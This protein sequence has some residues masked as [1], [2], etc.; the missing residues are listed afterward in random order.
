MTARLNEYYID[1]I[2]TG[3]PATA[4]LKGH[5]Y[6]FEVS[7]TTPQVQDHSFV[8]E[9]K[10]C[11]AQPSLNSQLRSGQS[12]RLQIELSKPEQKII[13]PRGNFYAQT[14]GQWIMKV[15]DTG[16]SARRVPI[17][18]GRQ[19]TEHYE[20]ISGLSAGDRVL[21]SGYDAFGDAEVVK[22]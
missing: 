15:D 14:S 6:A 17:R 21:I 20:V 22:W 7:R 11:T 1:R 18:L 10:V 5:K 4:T 19:N 13:I 12:L 3:L 9:L 16:H 2:Q 8:V